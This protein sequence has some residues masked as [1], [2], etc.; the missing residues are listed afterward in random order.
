MHAAGEGWERE[1]GGGAQ[2]S[3]LGADFEFQSIK[4]LAFR[5]AVVAAT[6]GRRRFSSRRNQ[7]PQLSPGLPPISPFFLSH[8]VILSPSLISRASYRQPP[9]VA[10]FFPISS[11]PPA[12]HGSF[13]A[14]IHTDVSPSPANSTPDVLQ[15]PPRIPAP[16]FPVS[17]LSLSRGSSS[18]T[19]ESAHTYTHV[20][21]QARAFS[22]RSRTRGKH[23]ATPPPSIADT[24]E[25]ANG[26]K[27]GR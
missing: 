26:R 14:E 11:L 13:A 16:P 4:L 23:S 18:T 17:Y 19:H 22:G 27:G 8:P 6:G 2:E 9:R 10:L 3:K 12:S 21:V 1:G 24:P 7:P 25:R 15:L 5:R 20:Y